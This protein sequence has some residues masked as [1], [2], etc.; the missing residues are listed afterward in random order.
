[1]FFRKV[2]NSIFSS[3]PTAMGS[4]VKNSIFSSL[5]TAMGSEVKNGQKN[6]RFWR[7]KL[8][9]LLCATADQK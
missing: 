9:L 1:M 2:K 5:P 6:S 3:L 4:E 8:V 7:E